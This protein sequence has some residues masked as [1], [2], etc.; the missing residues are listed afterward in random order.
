MKK[1][2]KKFLSTILGALDFLKEYW[3]IASVVAL[4]IGGASVFPFKLARAEGDIKD[5]KDQTT[6]IY[7]WVKQEQQEK[8]FEKERVA[9]A[10]PGYRWDS[11]KREYIKE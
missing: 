2:L 4:S 8:E 9:S 3:V 11:G 1:H 7:S 10:P 6:A 5:L